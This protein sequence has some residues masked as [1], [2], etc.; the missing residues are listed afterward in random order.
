M[1][2]HGLSRLHITADAHLSIHV[3]YLDWTWF[4]WAGIYIISGKCSANKVYLRNPSQKYGERRNF[5]SP[6][7]HNKQ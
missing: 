2:M 6:W 4:K 7:I 1:P 5:L 3:V